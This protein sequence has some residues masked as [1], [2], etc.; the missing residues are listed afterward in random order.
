[1]TKQMTRRWDILRVIRLV[2]GLAVAIQG[3]MDSEV[4]LV[5]AGGL[6]ASMA[7]LNKGCCSTAGCEVR[8]SSGNKNKVV[9][10][11]NDKVAKS[12]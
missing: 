6:V 4:I 8:H 2:L 12:V 9:E 1:M 11:T 3:I 7:L 5:M 10:V